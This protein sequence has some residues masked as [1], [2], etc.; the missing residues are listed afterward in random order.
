[1]S[2]VLIFFTA[3]PNG[4]SML[5]GLRLLNIARLHSL[6]RDWM[7]L[8]AGIRPGWMKV[9]TKLDFGWPE[10]WVHTPKCC[11]SVLIIFSRVSQCPISKN[12]HFMVSP[13]LSDR[14]MCS[15]SIWRTLGIL[16]VKDR[17]FTSSL[18]PLPLAHSRCS[19]L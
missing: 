11:F 3:L 17:N 18:P 2:F 12:G 9:S 5:S 8:L 1:M 4:F 19:N 10:N 15:I 6:A 14:P 7:R 16:V 13:M